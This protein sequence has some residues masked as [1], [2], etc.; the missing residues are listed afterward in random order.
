MMT[1][2]NTKTYKKTKTQKKTYTK[3]FKDSMYG[4]FSKSRGF[5]DLTYDID[6][7]SCDDKY[8]ANFSGSGSR[9]RT[10]YRNC[11][12]GIKFQSNRE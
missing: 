6:M 10:G 11:F 3:C 7:S 8:K 5:K 4:I 2:T 1:M 12:Y 9:T